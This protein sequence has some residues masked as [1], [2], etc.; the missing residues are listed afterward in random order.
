MIIG[1]SMFSSTRPNLDAAR[2]Y[3]GNVVHTRYL[4]ATKFLKV[5]RS[6]VDQT[7]AAAGVLSSE[8]EHDTIVGAEISIFPSI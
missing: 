7:A 1:S 3:M 2:D 8:P 5:A 4:N 6:V